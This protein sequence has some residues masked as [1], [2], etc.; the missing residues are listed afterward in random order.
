ME[1]VSGAI[2]M[3]YLVGGLF[4]FR[5]WRETRD[6]LFGIFGAAFWLL[7]GQR[8][9]LA[10]GVHDRAE[11]PGLYVLRLVAFVLILAAIVDK[12]RHSG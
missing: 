9:W 1:F 3:G 12:N 11:H 6:R 7:A 4:F 10:L 2:V 8:A 5:F